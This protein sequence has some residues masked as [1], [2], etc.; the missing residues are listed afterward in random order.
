MPSPRPATPALRYDSR[1]IL[2]LLIIPIYIL[3]IALLDIL[4]GTATYPQPFALLLLNVAFLGVIPIYI[5]YVSFVSF[6]RSGFASILM[7]GSGMLFIGLGAIAAGLVGLL[8]GAA[9]LVV[10]VHN[11]STCIGASLQFAGALTALVG[12]TVGPAERRPS[13][14]IS[15]YAAVVAVTA[16]LVL[17]TLLGLTPTFFAPVTGATVLRTLVLTGAIASLLIASVLFFVLYRKRNEDFFFWYA[18]GLALISLGLIG[19]SFYSVFDDPLN[20][21]ARI[22]Q[23]IGACF[24]LVAF[25]VLQ[26]RATSGNVSAQEML[27][28]FFVDAEAGYRQL[29]ETAGDAIIVLDPVR[30]V[31]LWNA[32]AG[33]LFGYTADEAVGM[34]FAD[35]VPAGAEE[36]PD[37]DA[38]PVHRETEA[39]RRDGRTVPIELAASRRS[40]DGEPITTCIIRDLSERRAAEAALRETEQRFRLAL[41]NAPVSVSVQ[42]RDLRYVWAYNQR[43]ATPEEIIGK[44]DA[45]IFTSADAARLTAIKRRVLEEDVEVREQMWLDR[46]GGPIYLE[47]YFE[48]VHDE[49]GRVTGVGSATV[50]LT[51]RRQAEEAIAASELKYRQLFDSM[52]EAFALHELVVDGAGRPVD[53]RFVAVNP[54]FEEMTGLAAGE[55]IGRTALEVLPGLE[56]RWIERYGRVADDG[57]ARA[58][59]GVHGPAR[60]LVRRA[61]VLP[62]PGPVRD[63]LHRRHRLR[64]W[65]RRR[66]AT[67]KSGSGRS[68]RQPGRDAFRGPRDGGRILDSRTRQPAVMLGRTEEDADV[69]RGRD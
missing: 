61:G 25:L 29:I 65:P 30:R 32:A 66:C 7:M 15:V 58:F 26:R 11:T 38:G 48:P 10:T 35:L 46:P 60:S 52:T 39:R 36:P 17:A 43:T 23:Y 64:T 18:I 50:D 24:L 55:I 33:R 68:T 1:K 31:L 2:S 40:I 28:R 49:A 20:W 12:W 6:R 34:P 53:Y 4:G 27:A 9:N 62:R 21:A 14:A 16:G 51:Q 5:A 37:G 59:H 47:I 13:L 22:E 19:V 63:G 3:V 67:A 42:G 54:A 45:D 44:R 56:R 69:G 41:R 57:R 8:P